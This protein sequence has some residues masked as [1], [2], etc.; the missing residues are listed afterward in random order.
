MLTQRSA[1]VYEATCAAEALALVEGE[2]PDI[3]ISD[4]GMPGE[5]GYSLI[6]RV[7]ALTD[8]RGG[9][10]P[11]ITVT[12]YAGSADRERA[13]D[14]GFDAHFAKPLDIDALVSILVEMR[15]EREA[16]RR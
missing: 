13:L 4:I 16:T 10:T 7:R 1:E 11:A 3:L 6:G 2:R 12:A 5:D 14:A 8:D 9:R 15:A